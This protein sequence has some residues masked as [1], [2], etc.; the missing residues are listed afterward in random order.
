MLFTENKLEQP[1]NLT[2]DPLKLKRMGLFSNPKRN[3]EE[4]LKYFC[5]VLVI[6]IHKIEIFQSL[7]EF[8]AYCTVLVGGTMSL[9]FNPTKMLLVANNNYTLNVSF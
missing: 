4:C 3:C 8:L 9:I 7:G 5:S 1:E 6:K 2:H